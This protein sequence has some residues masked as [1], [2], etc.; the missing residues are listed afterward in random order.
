VDDFESFAR[1]N[2]P[3]LAGVAYLLCGHRQTAEDLVQIAL[4]KAH[5]SWP[6]VQAADRPDAYVRQILVREYLSWRRRRSTTEVPSNT[7]VLMDQLADP[8][9]S[10][11]DRVGETD[12][13]WQLLH[14][15][16]RQQRAAL[17]MR[18]Y[19]DLPDAEIGSHLGCSA[20]T[21]RSHISRGLRKLQTLSPTSTSE[22]R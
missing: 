9:P 1:A 16:P 6:R 21:V 8:H 22:D 14:Q 15:L 20:V 4:T 11:M 19:L 5:R 7:I 3:A 17:V 10:A 12:E 2:G 18:F 13:M